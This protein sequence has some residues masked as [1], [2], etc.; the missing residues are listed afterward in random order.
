MERVPV[1]ENFEF[2]FVKF[3]GFLYGFN[4]G[5]LTLSFCQVLLDQLGLVKSNLVTLV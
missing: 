3:E 5:G 4:L 1:N 2:T